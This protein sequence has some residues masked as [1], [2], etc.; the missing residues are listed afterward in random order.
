MLTAFSGKGTPISKADVAAAVANLGGDEASLWALVAVETRGF[1]FLPDRRPQILFERH[2]FHKYTGGVF[3]IA[4]PDISNPT[5]GGYAG[6]AAE[7]DRLERAMAL[8]ETAA[9]KSASWGL[10]QV[11]GFNA[12][13]A[14]FRDVEA[15]VAAMVASEA[16]QMQAAVGFMTANHPLLAAYQAQVWAKLAFFY[17]GRNFAKKHYDDHLEHYHGI[18]SD[19]ANRP[20]IDLRTAQACLTYLGFY[21][22]GDSHHAV[23]DVDGVLGSRTGVALG[24]YRKAKGMPAGGLDDQ[25]LQLLIAEANI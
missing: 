16:S 21:P 5:P 6:G 17:N 22:Q 8:N 2:I 11:M 19:P 4:H 14:G 23:Q 13:T 10:G 7:Y 20:D 24:S 1:G 18:Y 15:M 3:T 9:L 25:V 12:Q